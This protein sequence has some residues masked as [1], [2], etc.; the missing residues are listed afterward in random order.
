MR[1]FDFEYLLLLLTASALQL[2]T[3]PTAL[4]DSLRFA[5]AFSAEPA[6]FCREWAH[7]LVVSPS[8]TWLPIQYPL[9]SLHL[10]L[11]KEYKL[12]PTFS[13]SATVPFARFLTGGHF[14]L[15]WR[16]SIVL[17]LSHACTRWLTSFWASSL[18]LWLEPIVRKLERSNSYGRWPSSNF[19]YPTRARNT[20]NY[21]LCGLY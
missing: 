1:Q 10:S 18:H 8:P 20:L 7:L 11:K 14:T 3:K 9:T 15:T 13:A 21:D 6:I 4:D 17:T 2:A 16:S 5:P 12:R 19:C